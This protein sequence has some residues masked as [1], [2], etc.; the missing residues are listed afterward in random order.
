MHLL[1]SASLSTPNKSN[2][3]PYRH[4][5]ITDY[6]MLS[7]SDKMCSDCS[8][9]AWCA[10]I[11]IKS[12]MILFSGSD[13]VLEKRTACFVGGMDS[14]TTHRMQYEACE[15]EKWPQII[16][17]TDGVRKREGER[18]WDGKKNGK[19]NACI[20]TFSRFVS[21]SFAGTYRKMKSF[22]NE[23]VGFLLLSKNRSTNISAVDQCARDTEKRNEQ[24]KNY[25]WVEYLLCIGIEPYSKACSFQ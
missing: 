13:S 21:K 3:F 25:N 14:R 7:D 15:D 1:I 5:D 8:V 16:F 17:S 10:H 24:E 6:A 23:I 18:E 4:I 2:N 20:S 19:M 9:S 12:M 22:E 11:L